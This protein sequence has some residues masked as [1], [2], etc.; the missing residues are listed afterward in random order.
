M[1]EIKLTIP[2]EHLSS[3]LIYL[4]TISYIK[5][6]QIRTPKKRKGTAKSATARA[7]QTL[8]LND[9]LRQAI[10]PIRSQVSLETIV[11]EQKYISTD[12]QKLKKIAQELAIQEPIELLLA[13]LKD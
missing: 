13:Q 5:I 9:P 7:L 3:F 4:E 8:P 10:K 6:E 12:W 1:S 11:Q 2:E